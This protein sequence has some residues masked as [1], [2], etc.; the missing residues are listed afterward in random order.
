MIIEDGTGTGRKAQ[1]NSGNRLYTRAVS[2]TEGQEANTDG[3]AYNINTGYVTLTNAVDTPL[4]Y[5][6]NNELKSLYIEG[7]A[8][9]VQPSTGGVSTEKTYAT[10]IRNPTA[11]TI[12]SNATDAPI[13]SN[14]NYGNQ[15]IFDA[16]VFVGGTGSTLTDGE[17]HLI[18]QL[19]EGNRAFAAV[20]EVI[21]KGASIAIKIK[22][23]TSN[24]SMDIYT[25][26]VCYLKEPNN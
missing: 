3:D 26:L 13:K 17:D 22:P 2:N 9:G 7:I 25:A 6:K 12:V 20:N 8:F 4:L 16:D 24:T 11:G 21:P 19:S 10:V 1:V 14:R 23:P 18:I 5:V 15:N